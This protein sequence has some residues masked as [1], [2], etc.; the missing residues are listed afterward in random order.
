LRRSADQYSA[1]SRHLLEPRRNM[2]GLAVRTGGRPMVLPD[3]AD[4]HLNGI[5]ADTKPGTGDAARFIA[6]N[7]GPLNL[8]SG[9]ASSQRVI[10]LRH[11]SAETRAQTVAEQT[12]A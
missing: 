12:G 8:E 7:D 2:D 10:F 3:N 6:G 4:Q 11:P 9:Q 5:D 1:R